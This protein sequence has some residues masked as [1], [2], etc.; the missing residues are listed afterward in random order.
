MTA[1]NLRRSPR[2]AATPY[3][4]IELERVLDRLWRDEFS[5]GG[6]DQVF[7]AVGDGKISIGVDVADVAGLEPAIF[8]SGLRFFGAIPVAFEDRRAADEN[9]AVFGDADFEVRAESCPPS[10]CD[11]SVA[12]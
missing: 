7:L 5:A 9:F 12:C 6:L 2:I 10:R 8:Q 4:G 1:A 3:I 11:G